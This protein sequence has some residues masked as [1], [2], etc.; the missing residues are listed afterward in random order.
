MALLDFIL[1]LA[2]L[3]LW[4][5]WR[6]AI[7][8]RR[9]SGPGGIT[10]AGTLKS[11]ASAR[12]PRWPY[13][14]ALGTLLVVR[15]LAYYTIGSNLGASMSLS[16]GVVT[17][18]FNTR[19][20]AR[21]FLFSGFSF[22]LFTT[23]FYLWLVLFS[24]INCRVSEPDACL[25]L[26]RLHLGAVQRQPAWLRALVPGIAGALGWLVLGYLLER[27]GMFPAQ[28]TAGGRLARMGLVGLYAYVCWIPPL[29]GVL[30][31]YLVNSYV[32]LGEAAFWS[33]VDTTGKNLLGCLGSVRLRVGRVDLTPAALAAILWVVGWTGRS[34]WFCGGARIL[35]EAWSWVR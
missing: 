15:S 10:L 9:D 11:T 33:F 20:L 18:P 34:G 28:A 32:Y 14:A 6:F 17:I 5:N 8:A 23:I 21:M 13:L 31:L 26:V 25:R 35:M 12:A 3:L 1:N 4:L 29:I 27:F 30:V 2:A 16:L 24:I 7:L 22:T 19:L